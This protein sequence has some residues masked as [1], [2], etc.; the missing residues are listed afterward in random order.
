VPV[1]DFWT[2]S[3]NHGL[4][5]SGAAPSSNPDGDEASNLVEY[6]F[7]MNPTFADSGGG[8]GSTPWAAGAPR[9]EFAGTGPTARIRVEFLRRRNAPDLNY[10]VQFCEHLGD[11]MPGGWMDATGPEFITPISPFW[12]HVVVWD[13]VRVGERPCRFGRVV[14]ELDEAP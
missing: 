6:A 4:E 7:D 1:T 2:W 13:S 12:E 3:A 10:R 5:G 8:G 14:V 9:V 11:A